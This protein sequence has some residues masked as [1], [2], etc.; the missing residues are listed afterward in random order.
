MTDTETGTTAVTIAI[1]TRRATP[2]LERLVSRV[3]GMACPFGRC[4]V[5]VVAED[6]SVREP[7]PREPGLGGWLVRVPFGRGLGFN[8]NRAVDESRGSVVAFV[9]DDCWPQDGWLAELLAPL[10]DPSIDAVTGKVKVPPST[11][12]G[13]AIA[14]LGFPGGGSEGFEV[15]YPVD[16]R[17]L[18]DHLAIGN[19]AVRRSALGRVGGFDETMTA[20][21]E[22]TELSY[23][24]CEAGFRIKYQPSAVVEHAARTSL[25]EFARWFFRRGRSV[26]QLSRRVREGP[27]IAARL[28][29]YGRLLA[30]HRRDPKLLVIVPLLFASVLLQETG[31]VWEWASGGR[32]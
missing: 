27:M 21:G 8:R 18:T 29:S 30:I 24:L 9:D 7:V 15:M 12:L 31:F 3:G 25:A 2:A 5:V 6:P 22:D 26:Y 19:S 4:E 16:A 20:G 11:F 28:A 14:A 23:R 32:R 1:V 13:D 10:A 17:G